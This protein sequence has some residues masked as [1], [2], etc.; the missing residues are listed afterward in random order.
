ML[1]TIKTLVSLEPMA[2]SQKFN[3]VLKQLK[4]NT[5][6]LFQISDQYAE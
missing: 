4:H 2:I 1:K 6:K 5:L 3:N